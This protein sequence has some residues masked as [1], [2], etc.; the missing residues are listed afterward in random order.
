MIQTLDIFPQKIGRFRYEGDLSLYVEEIYKIKSQTSNSV[1]YF[2]KSL[3]YQTPFNLF[4][5]YSV[6]NPIKNTI[7]NLLE[8]YY[9][10]PLKIINSW[11][12]IYP[13]F[14][15]TPFHSHQPSFSSGVL[16][17]VTPPNDCLN[18]HNK[19]FPEHYQTIP[20]QNGDVLFFNGDQPHSTYP[21]LSNKDKVIIAFNLIKV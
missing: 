1:K 17:L 4:D 3:Q 9:N 15:Y 10:L 19:N 5:K 2:P 18:I 16:Y 12:N 6:F 8:N 11:A 7:K 20:V 21:N 14:G 13:K